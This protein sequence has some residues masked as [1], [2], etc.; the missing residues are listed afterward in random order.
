MVPIGDSMVYLRPLYVAATT[1]PQPQL[2]YVVAVLGQ[3]VA[4]ESSLSAVLSDVLQATVSLP[5]SGGAAPTPATVP[6]AVSADL[7]AAQNDYNSA[8]ADLRDNNLAGYQQEI[9][10]MQQEISQAQQVLGPQSSATPNAA[11]TS[12]S[13]TTPTTTPSSGAKTSRSGS[14]TSSTVPNSTQPQGST[15]TTSP[16]SA[17][18]AP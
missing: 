2:Q 18:A 3:R 13:T 16:F 4:I 10:A 14:S 12:T 15:T 7:Q 9:Q 6:A 8:L 11:S 17:A 5:S 1:K